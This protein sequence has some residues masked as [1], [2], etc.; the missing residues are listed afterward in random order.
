[1]CTQE[2]LSN[3]VLTT[4]KRCFLTSYSLQTHKATTFCGIVELA[5]ALFPCHPLAN[6]L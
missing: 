5:S 3:G 6:S 4:N 1:M 2:N